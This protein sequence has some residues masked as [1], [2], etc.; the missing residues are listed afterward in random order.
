VVDPVMI[1]KTGF[2][3][4][5][6]EAKENLKIFLIPMAYLVTPIFLGW[7]NNRNKN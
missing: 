3:L 2:S 5:K 1:S 4:L 6:K 7:I